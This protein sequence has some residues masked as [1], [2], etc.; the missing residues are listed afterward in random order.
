[1]IDVLPRR[2]DGGEGAACTDLITKT[3]RRSAVFDNDLIFLG[4][5]CQP[6]H[7]LTLL[8]SEV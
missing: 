7:D 4:G 6:P 3:F 1:L 5:V 8:A 2:L